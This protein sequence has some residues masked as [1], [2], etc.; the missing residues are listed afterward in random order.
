VCACMC[1]STCMRRAT[2]KDSSFAI[3]KVRAEAKLQSPPFMH[4]LDTISHCKRA[5]KHTHT[6]MHTCLHTHHTHTRLHM[7]TTLLDDLPGHPTR[8]CHPAKAASAC[9]LGGCVSGF[10]HCDE[11]LGGT[12]EQLLLG[13]QR[14][15]LGL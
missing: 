9:D 10:V 4:L 3:Q 15:G 13:M 1:V 14:A 6:H 8:N 5:Q 2:A 12:S 7:L 11:T